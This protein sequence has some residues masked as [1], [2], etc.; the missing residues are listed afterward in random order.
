LQD[1]H[2]VRLELQERRSRWDRSKCRDCEEEEE[3]L[4]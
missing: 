4:M 2:M 3:E 1:K